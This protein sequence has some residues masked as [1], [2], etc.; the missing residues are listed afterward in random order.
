[1][2][3][4]VRGLNEGSRRTHISPINTRVQLLHIRESNHVSLQY[5]TTVLQKPNQHI[6]L[7]FVCGRLLANRHVV[8]MPFSKLTVCLI[9]DE[10]DGKEDVGDELVLE[11]YF[12]CRITSYRRKISPSMELSGNISVHRTLGTYRCCFG[13]R[14]FFQEL[15]TRT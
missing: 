6:K 15:N 11:C 9:L 2:K 12:F 10:A 4:L 13:G 1:M 14:R 3:T 8:W 5:A 7:G